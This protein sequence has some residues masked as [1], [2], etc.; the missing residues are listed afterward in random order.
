MFIWAVLV[1]LIVSIVWSFASLNTLK[2]D[3]RAI[4]KTKKDLLKRGK[5]VFQSSS[6][7]S[8]SE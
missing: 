7:D 5:V 4:E 6:S 1:I 2:K 8:S 3:K